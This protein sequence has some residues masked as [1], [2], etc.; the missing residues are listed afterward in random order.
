[1]ADGGTAAA[2]DHQHVGCSHPSLLHKWFHL[3]S[4]LSQRA[5]QFNAQPSTRANKDFMNHHHKDGKKEFLENGRRRRG[6]LWSGEWKWKRW[7]HTRGQQFHM[8]HQ[9][10][11]SEEKHLQICDW[12]RYLWDGKECWRTGCS[13]WRGAHPPH[14]PPR[15][16]PLISQQCL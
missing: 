2:W 13:R 3:I 8:L 14:R 7:G 1:M 4:N 15:G 5:G 12:L 9:H 16:I 11:P 6:E 10:S